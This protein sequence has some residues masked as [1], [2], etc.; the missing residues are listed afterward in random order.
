V[1]PGQN[2]VDAMHAA[3][4]CRLAHRDIRRCVVCGFDSDNIGEAVAHLRQHEAKTRADDEE[5]TLAGVPS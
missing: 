5:W 1:T 4:V 2:I 3:A